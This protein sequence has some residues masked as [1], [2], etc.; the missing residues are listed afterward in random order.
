VL[1]R[2]PC[3]PASVTPAFT[4]AAKSS[5]CILQGLPSHHI[6]AMP[7]WACA[8]AEQRLGSG[9]L[10]SNVERCARQGPAECCAC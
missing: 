4:C 3:S 1:N 5:R 6:L 8:R 2:M 7:I 10:A 9:A